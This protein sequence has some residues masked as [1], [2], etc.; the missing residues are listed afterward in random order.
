M[1]R[2]RAGSIAAPPARMAAWEPIFTLGNPLPESSQTDVLPI[3]P[4]QTLADAFIHSGEVIF[5]P[6]CFNFQ[7]MNDFLQHARLADLTGQDYSKR[8]SKC[9]L[10]DERGFLSTPACPAAEDTIRIS[11]EPTVSSVATSTSVKQ[12]DEQHFRAILNE[13]ELYQRL[14]NNVSRALPCIYSH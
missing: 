11:S 3:Q 12:V 10:I 2:P 14:K 8:L 7:P 5:S 9:C 4:W 6:P 1:F 13:A